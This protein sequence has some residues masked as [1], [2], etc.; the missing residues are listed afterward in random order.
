MGLLPNAY[1]QRRCRRFARR[2]LCSE[3]RRRGQS[4]VEH[5]SNDDGDDE[6]GGAEI[7]PVDRL[8]RKGS[9]FDQPLEILMLIVVCRCVIAPTR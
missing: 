5:R 1:G 4:G 2:D 9:F 7:E 6:T 8:K 3:H